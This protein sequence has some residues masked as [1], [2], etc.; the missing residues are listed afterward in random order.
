MD[1]EAAY[2]LHRYPYRENSFLLKVFT[3][4]EGLITVVARHAKGPKSDWYGLLQ[5]FQK[6]ALAYQGK[7]SVLTLTRAERLGT[8]ALLQGKPLFSGFYLNELLLKFLA[9]HDVHEDIFTAYE[10]A[11]I[12][13]GA[14]DLESTLRRF[15]FHLWDALGVLPDFCHDHHGEVLEKEIVYRLLPDHLPEKVKAS[16]KLPQ[17]FYG[18]ELE[19]FQKR[20]FNHPEILKSAKRFSRLW[21]EFYGVGKELKSR[22][23]FAEVFQE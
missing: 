1:L 18:Y 11:L 19:E 2:I 12:G 5:P 17:H 23:I 15:E 16:I 6:L 22:E 7:G 20:E 14:T 3:Q 21:L 8:S 10:L 9:P 13:L 4:K